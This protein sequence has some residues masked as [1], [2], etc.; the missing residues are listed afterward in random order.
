MISFLLDQLTAHPDG[1]F[2]FTGC[3]DGMAIAPY[4]AA[5]E[6]GREEDLMLVT[7]GG[8]QTP[9]EMLA[10]K[11]TGFYGYLEF[12]PY[13]E[14]WNWVVT[15]LAILEGERYE[16]YT[17]QIVTTKETIEERFQALYGDLPACQ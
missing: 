15:S 9:A 7:M 3:W 16:P 5:K 1:V 4:N 11:P 12:Q 10:C 2:A 13:C 6:A 17:P 8:D 14:G